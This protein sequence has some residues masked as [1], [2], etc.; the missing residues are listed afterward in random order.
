[1]EER[2]PNIINKNRKRKRL[3]V[4]ENSRKNQARKIKELRKK[5]KKFKILVSSLCFLVVL[6]L[7]VSAF[8]KQRSLQARRYE[9]NTLKAD[10][11]SYELQRDRLSQK[12]ENTIDINKIQRYALEDLGMVY[13]DKDNTVKLNVDRN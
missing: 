2:A 9:Y 11:I 5:D 7:A 4:K 13:T 12:L 3:K 8:F 6:S 1:M 10:I